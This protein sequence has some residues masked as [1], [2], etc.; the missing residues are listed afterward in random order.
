MAR[1]K[2]INWNLSAGVKKA[3]GTTE[4][5]SGTAALA[6][7]MDV[8]DELKEIKV[9]LRKLN[10]LLY[11]DDFVEIPHVLRGIRRKITTKKNG[12]P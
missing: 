12:A 4:Y 11:C 3:D 7:A 10:E 5:P 8:R 9:E 6:L 1:N 2:D